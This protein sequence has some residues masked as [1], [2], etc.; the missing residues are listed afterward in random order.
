MTI[1]S[2]NAL[3]PATGADQ[4][5]ID[6]RQMTVDGFNL[7]HDYCAEFFR[8]SGRNQQWLNVAKDLTTVIGTAATGILALS[9]P[10]NATAAGAVAL[11]T[12]TAYNG[13]DLYTR[14][15][16]FGADNIESVRV[17]T[18]NALAA[19]KSFVL[20]SPDLTTWTFGGAAEAI[21]D[22]QAICTTASIR[23]LVVAAI[24]SGTVTAYPPAGSAPGNPAAASINAIPAASQAAA[25]TL[26]STK[27]GVAPI[28]A[29]TAASSALA[30]A[31][32]AAAAGGTAASISSAATAAAVPKATAAARQAGA[33]QAEAKD[34]AIAATNVVVPAITAAVVPSTTPPTRHVTIQVNGQSAVK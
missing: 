33:S 5:S 18:M 3:P 34:A 21:N 2:G 8:T 7:V 31:T 32:T 1:S 6:A 20:P 30:A 4:A 22:H 24:N 15:F 19:H 26:P 29:M 12:A 9:S 28:T 11:G 10:A 13:V 27:A 25:H 17:L 23:A 14:N 16:L